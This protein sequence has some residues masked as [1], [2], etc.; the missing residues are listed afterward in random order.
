[1]RDELEREFPLLY[2]GNARIGMY[3]K[4]PINLTDKVGELYSYGIENFHIRLT[5]ES[6]SETQAILDQ[7]LKNK[8]LSNDYYRGSYY[9]ITL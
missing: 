4:E 2:E 7:I 3:S 1:L 5:S 6:E 8:I 9:K